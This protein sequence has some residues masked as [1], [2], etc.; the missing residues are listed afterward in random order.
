MTKPSNMAAKLIQ[1][2]NFCFLSPITAQHDG[3]FSSLDFSSLDSS[4]ES[5][6]NLAHAV[7][8]TGLQEQLSLLSSD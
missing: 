5:R 1:I 3:D 2:V 7:L 6:A 8:I 4:L